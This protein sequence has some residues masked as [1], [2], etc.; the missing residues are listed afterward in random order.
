MPCCVGEVRKGTGDRLSTSRRAGRNESILAFRLASTQGGVMM[1]A[2]GRSTV[3]REGV[4]L[5]R[6]WIAALP[7]HCQ[8]DTSIKD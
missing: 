8:N 2:L 5:I 3:H 4:Q 1:P 7:G 6:D